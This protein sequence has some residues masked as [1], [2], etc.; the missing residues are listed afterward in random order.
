MKRGFLRAA[1]GLAA[2]LAG[3]V[4]AII[5]VSCVM[6]GFA[7]G[8]L[9]RTEGGRMRVSE[10]AEALSQDEDGVWTMAAEKA[11]TLHGRGCWAMLLDAGGGV[12]WSQDMPDS[13]PRA[14]SSAQ[15]ASFSRWYLADWPVK[16]WTVGNGLF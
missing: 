8:Y 16:V 10:Y 7:V 9:S 13:L 6:C 1:G 4:A 3:V 12:V 14:Y 5:A 15:V 11:E 2:G